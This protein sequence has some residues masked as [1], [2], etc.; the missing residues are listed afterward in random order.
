[1]RSFQLGVGAGPRVCIAAETDAAPT[2]KL[3]LDVRF[4]PN[5]R[6]TGGGIPRSIRQHTNV[7]EI[8]DVPYRSSHAVQL[9]CVPPTTITQWLRPFDSRERAHYWLY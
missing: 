7:V 9:T 8:D 1:M 3:F 2:G 5:V 6:R 4:D